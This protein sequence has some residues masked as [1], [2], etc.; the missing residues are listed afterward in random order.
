M[1]EGTKEPAYIDFAALESVQDITFAVVP[2]PEWKMDTRIGSIPAAEMMLWAESREGPLKRTAGLRL[3]AQSLV[4]AKGD[5]LCKT[6]KDIAKA[7]AIFEKKN[8]AVVTRCIRA[9]AELNG[10]NEDAQKAIK[11]DSS[12]AA[13]DA[14]PTV[15]H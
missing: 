14:S 7:V 5:R 3:L 1:S 10:F 13:T 9:I 4:D 11:N 2:T 12:E 6:E 8:S 15:L